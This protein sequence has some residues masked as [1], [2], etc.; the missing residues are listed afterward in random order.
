MVPAGRGITK[1]FVDHREEILAEVGDALFRTHGDDAARRQW[2]KRIFAGYDNDATLEGWARDTQGRHEGRTMGRVSLRVGVTASS[3]G[4]EFKPS[5]Y[6]RAQKTS[7]AWMWDHAGAELREY[8][9]QLRPRATA[10][11]NMGAWKS[12]V[13]QE[14]EAAGRGAKLEWAEAQGIPVLSIQHDGIILGRVGP[15]D[16]DEGEGAAI[17]EELSRVVSEAVGYQVWVKVTW[18]AG[19]QRVLQVD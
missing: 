1:A 5:D 9:T 10:K 8:L 13:L 11:A 2:A 12:Y 15:D 4:V 6:W 16:A 17:R 3:P 18:C 7:T 19:A 14:A